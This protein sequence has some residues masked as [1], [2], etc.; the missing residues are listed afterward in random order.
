MYGYTRGI[1]EGGANFRRFYDN[2]KCSVASLLEAKSAL[3]LIITLFKTQN[4]MCN[5]KG[6]KRF[7]WNRLFSNQ[8]EF[9]SNC[10][11]DMAERW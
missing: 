3:M 8:R 9:E 6:K 5:I 7:F 4:C 1:F 2:S 11:A 10:P